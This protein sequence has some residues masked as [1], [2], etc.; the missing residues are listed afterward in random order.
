MQQFVDFIAELVWLIFFVLMALSGISLIGFIIYEI[1]KKRIF[2]RFKMFWI[3]QTKKK[4]KKGARKRLRRLKK[5]IEK[6]RKMESQ[7]VPLWIRV[8]YLRQRI[9]GD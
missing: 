8:R 1:A 2:L 6:R 5:S 7:K 9:K 3:K 4:R